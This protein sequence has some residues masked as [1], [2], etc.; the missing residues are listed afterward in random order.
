MMILLGTIITPSSRPVLPNLTLYFHISVTIS[1][2]PLTTSHSFTQWAAV[3]MVS[4]LYEA[5]KIY[6]IFF[7][8]LWHY[9]NLNLFKVWGCKIL[10]FSSML[11]GKLPPNKDENQS[12]LLPQALQIKNVP[13]DQNCFGTSLIKAPPQ[14]LL[15]SV[16]T[17]DF[18]SFV[19]FCLLIQIISMNW[20]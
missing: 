18:V 2:T 10:W 1:R 7:I 15:N 8:I 9:C 19:L 6:I 17:P 5:S 4:E 11:E 13:W 3:K 16:I 20:F 12:I 14:T